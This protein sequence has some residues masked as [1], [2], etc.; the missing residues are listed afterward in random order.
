M[1][2]GGWARNMFG[3]IYILLVS[4]L[5]YKFLAFFFTKAIVFFLV[6]MLNTE[7]RHTMPFCMG[8]S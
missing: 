6:L 1:S 4:M 3:A 8:I 7:E 5:S 2:M